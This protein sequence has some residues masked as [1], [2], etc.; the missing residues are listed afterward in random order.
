MKND[1]R[2]DRDDNNSV[3]ENSRCMHYAIHSDSEPPERVSESDDDAIG[4]VHGT[5]HVGRSQCKNS[6]HLCSSEDEFD[7]QTSDSDVKRYS[8]L[9][10]LLKL[11]R[12]K[13]SPLYSYLSKRSRLRSKENQ[14]SKN[15]EKRDHDRAKGSRDPFR[16]TT[17]CA[18][19]EGT[20]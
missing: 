12:S 9:L 5:G 6:E 7:D 19:V 1:G 14:G 8:F 2:D 11:P 4:N 15:E 3:L 20:A 17:V 13:E 10:S 16:G 18:G